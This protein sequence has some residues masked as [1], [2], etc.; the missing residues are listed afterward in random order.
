MLAR[1]LFRLGFRR[2]M[3]THADQVRNDFF[4]QGRKARQDPRVRPMVIGG[5]VRFGIGGDHFIAL[6]EGCSYHDGFEVLA[7]TQEHLSARAEGGQPPGGALLDVRQ[8]ER[9]ASHR[10]ESNAAALRFLHNKMVA[11]L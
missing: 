7:K 4:I 10:R 2:E 8:I 11:R 6:L 5:V 9:G 1:R 3:P